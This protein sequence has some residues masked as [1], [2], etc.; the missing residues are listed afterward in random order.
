M[1][2]IHTA[3]EKV[4][5]AFSSLLSQEFQLNVVYRIM[6]VIKMMMMDQPKILCTIS[7]ML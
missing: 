6:W 1:K 2:K 4:F 7:Q 3:E 5:R